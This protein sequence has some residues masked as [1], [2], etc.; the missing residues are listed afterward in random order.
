MATA[1]ILQALSDMQSNA[2]S[3]LP[4]TPNNGNP[5]GAYN[6]PHGGGQPQQAAPPDPWPWLKPSPFMDALYQDIAARAERLKQEMAAVDAAPIVPVEQPMVQPQALPQQ[7]P[8]T[9]ETILP[10][11]Q[12]QPIQQMPPPV[13]PV[14]NQMVR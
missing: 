8:M 2:Q 1:Q 14:R 6:M 4:V 5:A 7:A 9:L 3:A 13:L 10:A 12:A 11:L